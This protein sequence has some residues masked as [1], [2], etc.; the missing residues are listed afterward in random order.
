MSHADSWLLIVSI[1]CSEAAASGR[2]DVK[3]VH[4]DDQL[5]ARYLHFDGRTNACLPFHP[6]HVHLLDSARVCLS[7]PSGYILHLN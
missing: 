4:F 3:H 2:L 6:C 5:D 7:A 1:I